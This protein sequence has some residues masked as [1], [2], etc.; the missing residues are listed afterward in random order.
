MAISIGDAL[1]KLGLDSSELDAGLKGIKGKLGEISTAWAGVGV[2]I[3]GGMGMMIKAAADEQSNINRLGITL[4]N[5]GV[6]YDNVKDSLEGVI[7]ATQRKTGIA[8]SEQR[9]VLN[10]LLLVTNDYNKAL[11][12][13]PTVLDLA[14]AGGMDA[15]TAATYL[16]KAYLDLEN[17]AEQVSVRF[18][19]ASLQF[20]SMEDIQKRVAGAAE[21]VVNPFIVLKGEISDIAEGIGTSFLPILKDLVSR[22]TEVSSKV[23]EW[24]SQNPE[25]VKA[26]AA[27]ALAIAGII[28]VVFALNAVLLLLG[29][30]ANLMFGGILIA[31]GLLV[32]AGVLLWQNWDKVGHFFADMWS[33][34]KIDVLN[35]VNTILG[36]L[37]KLLGWIPGLGDKL[38][39]AHDAIANMIDAEKVKKDL[40]DVQQA[41]KDTTEIIDQNAEGTTNLTT[42]L[43]ENQ[44]ALEAQLKQIEEQQKAYQSLGESVIKTRKEF[45]Y[46]NSDA[47]RLN[48]TLKDVIFALFDLGWTND[49][50]TDTLSQLGDEGDNVNAVLKAVGLTA[51]QVNSILEKQTEAIDKTT[52]AYKN[53]AS[54]AA[55][56]IAAQAAAI[57]SAGAAAG[58]SEKEI[59]DEIKFWTPPSVT[60][61][62]TPQYAKEYIERYAGEWAKPTMAQEFADVYGPLDQY[63]KGGLI[64]EP[65]L[66]YGLRS[67]KPYA[68]AGEAGPERVGGLGS[69][70]ISGNNFYVRQDS[71][72]DRIGQALVDKIRARTGL[73]I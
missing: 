31:V 47:G 55:D 22:F 41:L 25:L 10:R 52:A 24:V 50:V 67:M 26:L 70:L 13:M 69:V 33:D 54:A 21:A 49:K 2:A 57:R 19:Q 40:H 42:A 17:G 30:T 3:V 73:K 6:A 58:K 59:A 63:Q 44:V 12:L 53:Q 64:T 35:S 8:D 68:I 7:T 23:Q 38:R 37:E 60:D 15:A 72:I 14:A 61:F 20:K 27:G 71:D 5:V 36:G 46:E 45:E 29:A 48:L 32:T 1:L 16:G 28:T 11:E 56:S 4:K 39:S 43:K 18:G 51:D 9:D 66:L 65:T 62:A 34:L